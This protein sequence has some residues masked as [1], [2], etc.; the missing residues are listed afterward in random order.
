MIVRYMYNE[1]CNY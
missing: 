1:I